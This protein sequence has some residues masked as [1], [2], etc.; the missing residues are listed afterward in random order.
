MVGSKCLLDTNA[1]IALQHDDETLKR[2]LSDATDVFVPAVAIGELYFGAYKSSKVEQN[3]KAI[4]AFIVGRVVLNVD[5]DT[6]D[7]YGQIKQDLRAKG[8]PIPENDIWI[9][10]LAMQYSLTLLSRDAH[11]S[12]ISNLTSQTW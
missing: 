1:I 3:R 4:A 12:E 11:F 10:A 7:I 2:L 5:T 6:A 8:R 9:A